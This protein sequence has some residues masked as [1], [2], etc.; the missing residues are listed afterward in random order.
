MRPSAYLRGGGRAIF[1][2][3]AWLAHLDRLGVPVVNGAQA[4][5]HETSKALQMNLLEALG[6]PYPRARVINHASQ[7]PAAADGL[8]FPV[9]VKAN[10]G[11][12][13]AGIV[14]YETPEALAEASAREMLNLGIDQTALVQEYVPRSE[15]RRVGR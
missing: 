14:R 13:G 5:R 15:E 4:W 8:R 11:G 1:Y 3:Y 12:S 6:L 7:A 9:V 10:I 2:T